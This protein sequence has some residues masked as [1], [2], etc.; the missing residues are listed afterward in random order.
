MRRDEESAGQTSV[1]GHIV[2]ASGGRTA[3]VHLTQVPSDVEVNWLHDLQ[4]PCRDFTG[5]PAE[6]TELLADVLNGLAIVGEHGLGGVG[7]TAMALILAELISSLYLEA[8]FYLE[9]KNTTTPLRFTD[10]LA[11]VIPAY[12]PALELPDEVSCTLSIAPLRMA[13]RSCCSRTMPTLLQWLRRSRRPREMSEALSSQGSPEFVSQLQACTPSLGARNST[14]GNIRRPHR[15]L[16][17]P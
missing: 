3:T 12:H 1:G 4:S 2:Q 17:S 9:F 8:Q 13:R 10:A 15:T 6:L 14:R 16:L 7:K 5:G 11:H